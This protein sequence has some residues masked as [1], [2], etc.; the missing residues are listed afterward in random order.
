M[1]AFK[2]VIAIFSGVIVLAIIATLVGQNAKTGSIL[3]TAFNGLSSAITAAEAPVTTGGGISS[4][5]SFQSLGNNG[6]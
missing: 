1:E 6:Y 3:G 4:L 2:E 5:S